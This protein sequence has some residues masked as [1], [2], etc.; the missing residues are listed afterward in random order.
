MKKYGLPYKGSKSGIAEFILDNL[1]MKEN[2][3]DLFAGGCSITHAALL[4]KKWKHVYF[5]D[6]NGGITQLFLDAI[7]GKYKDETRWISREDFFALKDTDPYVCYCWS[8]GNN[9]RSYL[10]S[11][12]I[13]PYKKACHFAIVFD[14]WKLLE[15]LCPEV[16]DAAKKALEGMGDRKLRRLRFGPS[17]VKE[18][19]RLGDW[20]LVQNNPLYKSCHWRGGKLDGKQNDLQSLQSLERLQS[21]QSLNMSYDEIEIKPDSVV[22]C[23]IPYRNTNDYGMD[24]DYEKFYAWA[25]SQ[26][27]LVVISEY[28]M[29]EDRFTCVAKIK[30]TSTLCSIKTNTVQEKLFVPVHQKSMFFENKS[31]EQLFNYDDL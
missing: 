18:L 28:S 4:S 17:I 24:F 7:S 25:E 13:E 22:Y 26:R 3:Y 31:Q 27:E 9:G 16:V 1:P 2:F 19:K 23:D 14:E 11:K 29:P 21:L 15:E 12:E 30:H 5:N 6:I 20:D 10:Y 8:F